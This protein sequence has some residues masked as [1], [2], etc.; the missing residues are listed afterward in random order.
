MNKSR[1]R[2]FTLVELLVVIAI[3]GILIGMLLPAVQSVREAAR[4][5]Q[6]LNNLKQST[7][8]MLNYESAHGNFPPGASIDGEQFNAAGERVNAQRLGVSYW[9]HTL[10]FIE[11][12]N[13]AGQYKIE[14]GGWTR[15][16]DGS[17]FNRALIDGV[18]LSF[19]LCPSSAM[20]LFPADTENP[21][22]VTVGT[23]GNAAGTIPCYTGIAGSTASPILNSDGTAP[24]TGDEGTINSASGML[25]SS[26]NSTKGNPEFEITF[27]DITDGESNTMVLGEQSDFL[28]L[29]RDSNG[30]FV[31]VDGRSDGNHGFALGVD[32]VTRRRF[33]Q[34]TVG[35][36]AI[37]EKTFF[38]SLPVGIDGNLA[39]NRPLV[40]AH[41]GGVN[42]SLA[43]GSTHFLADSTSTLI[44]NSLADRNDGNVVSVR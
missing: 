23:G 27:G 21:A 20:S 15:A 5:T 43:D 22:G 7:L 37:N 32:T 9:V 14:E 36:F 1:K 24:A 38:G 12:N 33:N 2:G 41:T 31:N 6:C 42:T 10:P 29:D 25:I 3:I 39:S 28:R 16:S 18:E 8:A 40:S 35:L 19:L 13:L 30:Q 44:L 4:R 34:T 26:S 17:A 11:Q